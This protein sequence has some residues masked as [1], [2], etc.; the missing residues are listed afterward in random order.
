MSLSLV[1]TKAF[2]KAKM[3]QQHP[4][5]R[6]LTRY[7]L[8]PNMT[9]KTCGI[10]SVKSKDRHIQNFLFIHRR[11]YSILFQLPCL[12]VV[13][14]LVVFVV[15]GNVVIIGTWNCIDALDYVSVVEWSN[16]TVA[17]DL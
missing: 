7:Y 12:A 4:I 1:C 14:V 3:I 11:L 5:P 9:R 16:S 17:S 2:L 15:A 8:E 10:R 13:V 6:A